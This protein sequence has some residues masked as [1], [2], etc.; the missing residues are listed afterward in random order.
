MALWASM[1]LWWLEEEMG[2]RVSE[3]DLDA[4][5][6]GPISTHRTFS[7]RYLR[8]WLK[9]FSR[10]YVQHRRR[11]DNFF[12]H[13]RPEHQLLSNIVSRPVVPEWLDGGP[14]V[15]HDSKFPVSLGHIAL[16][17]CRGAFSFNHDYSKKIFFYPV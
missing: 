6:E 15:H 5:R 3:S 13:H 2:S 10:R 1:A 11:G 14:S 12:R 8:P 17:P 16:H 7:F 9:G 4:Q